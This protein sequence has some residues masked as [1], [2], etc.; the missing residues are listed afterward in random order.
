MERASKAGEA[1][2]ACFDKGRF[3][4][5]VSINRARH[6]VTV[7]EMC[8]QEHHQ[9]VSLCSHYNGTLGIGWTE[10]LLKHSE[11]DANDEGPSVTLIF[12]PFSEPSESLQA[13]AINFCWSEYTDR[14][15]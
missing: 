1:C 2:L 11:F 14:L 4:Y 7:I 3:D 6:L 9:L 15:E 8:R 10:E 12:H 5:F 13:E